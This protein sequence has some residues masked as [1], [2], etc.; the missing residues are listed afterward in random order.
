MRDEQHAYASYLLRLRRSNRIW[1]RMNS[2][3]D[4]ENV[5]ETR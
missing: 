1:H 4:T 2:T 5:L 3:P